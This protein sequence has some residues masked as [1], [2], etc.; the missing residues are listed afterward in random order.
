MITRK[1][2]PLCTHENR[3]T[4]EEDLESMNISSDEMDKQ[5]EWPSGT[6]SKH[7]RNHMGHYENSSNPRCAICTSPIRIEIESSLYSGEIS[8]T[9][10]AESIRCTEAQVIRH[11]KSHLQPLVQQSAANLIATREVNEIESLS[12]NISRLDVKLDLLFQD[13]D[14]SPK[15]IDSLTKLAKEV[16]ESLKYLM[17]FKGKLVHKRQDTIIVHQMQIIKEVLAQNHPEVWLDVR[18]K[19]EEKLQ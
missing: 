11:V 3:E 6:S 7:Q 2:C 15:A 5:M 9:E 4:Y 19:M 14:V 18:N 13:D 12:S 10:V 16:R 17:E 1:R 8:A